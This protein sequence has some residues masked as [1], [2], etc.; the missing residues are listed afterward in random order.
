LET[1]Y[2]SQLTLMT[3][4]DTVM[5]IIGGVPLSK[6]I[7]D[8]SSHRTTFATTGLLAP[9]NKRASHRFLLSLLITTSFNSTTRNSEFM[10]NHD[11]TKHSR[12]YCSHGECIPL[13]NPRC[14]HSTESTT[15]MLEQTVVFTRQLIEIMASSDYGNLKTL[16]FT[17]HC[18][19]LKS[20]T[21]EILEKEWKCVS[22][23]SL[24]LK[25]L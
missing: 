4:P 18:Q 19:L 24:S 10:S 15:G 8:C 23:E 1:P 20:A 5:E 9:E 13:W 16:T 3:G 17:S 2:C 21:L 12:K 11:C 7:R 6:K 25:G 14:R 22:L